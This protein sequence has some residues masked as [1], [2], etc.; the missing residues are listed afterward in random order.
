[1]S[2]SKV[3]DQDDAIEQ[4]SVAL[5]ST[6]K[7]T[8]AWLFTGPPGS[9][10][11]TLALEFAVRILLKN[12]SNA[13]TLVESNAHPDV[14]VLG[15][16]GLTIKIDVVR[17][18]I[19]KAAV[20][21]TLGNRKIFIIK[22]ADRMTTEAQ[23]ALL[24]SIEE[25]EEYMIWILCAPT[26]HDV[27]PTISSRARVVNLRLARTGSIEKLLVSE[28]VDNK[29]AAEV[30][31]LSN[32]HIGIARK[33][34]LNSELYEQRLSNSELALSINYVSD[35]VYSAQILIKNAE[36]LFKQ[37]LDEEF[38]QKI[39]ELRLNLGLEEGEV[40]P[41][42]LRH[43]FKTVE[44]EKKSQEKRQLRDLLD[45]SLQEILM[46][47]RDISL[48]QAGANSDLI[49]NLH[50]IDKLVVYAKS[51]TITETA[52]KIECVECARDR[53]NNNLGA[54]GQLVLEA[55]FAA[56]LIPTRALVH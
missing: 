30:A 2:W 36:N 25:P 32:G 46:V 39:H 18:M 47:Y 31:R 41:A 21:P 17:S 27:L 43:Y 26:T 50:L 52:L 45:V 40:V 8:N 54:S 3:I 24:K 44:D 29:K 13:R 55:M 33:L 11:S 20:F 19:A 7:M 51:M 38:E 5:N 12:T 28:G 15:A 22:D 53:I 49:I 16:S 37:L 42:K 56:L 4:L 14:E 9:G 6:S 48:L 10:R 1:M 23:N 35:A 34:A